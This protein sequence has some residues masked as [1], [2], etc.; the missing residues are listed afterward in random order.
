MG[1]FGGA[2]WGLLLLGAGLV[3][4]AIVFLLRPRPQPAMAAPA[5]GG[6][7]SEEVVAQALEKRRA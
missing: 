2:G 3:F 5:Y 6:G 4:A 1:G 7:H